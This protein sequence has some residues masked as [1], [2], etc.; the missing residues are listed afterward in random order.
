MSAQVPSTPAERFVSY[1]QNFEDV[2]LWRALGHVQRGFYIDAGAQSPDT[3]SVTKAFYLAGWTGINIEPH[4]VYYEQ[5]RGARPRDVNLDVA[6][7]DCSGS[8]TMNLIEGSGLSTADEGLAEQYAVAGH[9]LLKHEVQMST[10]RQVWTKNVAPGQPVHFL[11]VDVE[12]FERAVLA[13]N[14]WQRNR[15]WIILVEA[16]LPNSQIESYAEW[17][18]IL[19]DA[20]Y[21]F[22]YADGLNRFYVAKEHAELIVRFK[23][24][25]NVFD[26]FATATEHH[27]RE[28]E[29][30]LRRDLTNIHDHAARLSQQCGALERSLHESHRRVEVSEASAIQAREHATALQDRLEV[31][32]A[33]LRHEI[34]RRD[35]WLAHATQRG[36]DEERRADIAER[37]R[38]AIL[39]SPWWRA[40][41]PVRRLVAALPQSVRRSG[42]RLLRAVTWLLTPW[43]IPSRLRAM[44]E[45]QRTQSP[46]PEDQAAM[47]NLYPQATPGRP[48]CPS[49]PPAPSKIADRATAAKWCLSLLRSDPEI[50]ARFPRALSEP[51]SSG[52]IDWVRQEGGERFALSETARLLVT[53]VLQNDF[54][55]GARRYFLG[56][57]D[58]RAIH[59]DGLSVSGLQGMY[60]WF[61]LFGCDE[62]Q[63]SPDE[64]LW[65]AIQISEM[66]D[67]G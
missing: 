66:P 35:D 64:V 8:L 43:R 49:I 23:F 36:V 30:I 34:G 14:D 18:P 65:L 27:F 19:S 33:A 10:L 41:A 54:G 53:T 38:D 63:L 25:P 13:G 7:G 40:T 15:P 6:L 50:R 61:M 4:P 11:K 26:N 3:D 37:Q 22:A 62:G 42:C 60:R 2:M 56:R 16:T 47:L 1:A 48:A 5:L 59:P 44:A 67:A 31:E 39:Q 51:Q 12:G 45:R 28:I 32:T 17:E 24:P 20:G 57:S 21:R 9:V 46:A 58:V 52:F 55:G 29:S